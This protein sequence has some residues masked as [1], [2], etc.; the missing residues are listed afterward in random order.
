MNTFPLTVKNE[1]AILT[2][3]K[4]RE[5]TAVQYRKTE[6]KMKNSFNIMFISGKLGG[7]DGVS[8]EVDK[9]I[10]SFISQGHKIFTLAGKYICP[11]ENVKLE[12]QFHID[13][14]RFDHPEQLEIE[15]EV[16]PFIKNNH[17]VIDHKK[18]PKEIIEKIES[19]GKEIAE[20][21]LSYITENNIDLIIAENTNAMPMSMIGGMGVYILATKMKIATLFHHHDFWWERSRFSSNKIESLLNKIM[22]PNDNIVEHSV[23]TTYSAHI[24]RSL[25]RVQPIVIPNCENFTTPTVK[26]DYNSDFRKE[27]GFKEDD[28]L[29]IQPTRI[30]RRKK[31]EDSI[32]LLG[33]FQQKYPQYKGRIQYIISLYQG[34]EPDDNYIDQIHDLCK[35][36]EIPLHLISDRVSS[37]RGFNK[38][39]EKLY[40][41]RDVL[42]QCD[43]ATYLPVW[44]GFGNAL[45]EAIACRIP[46]VITTYLVY[47]TDI[48]ITG[49]NNIEIRD[50]YTDKGELI[51]DD[52]V[53]EEIFNILTNKKLREKMIKENFKIA[54]KE[55]GMKTLNDKLKHFLDGYEYEIKASRKRLE[56]IN[57]T[58]SV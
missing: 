4:Y 28:I 38:N 20:I 34:D 52:T 25:K 40:T 49:I 54:K 48:K 58:Y 29:I 13:D 18:Q 19:R 36:W 6:V 15:Q 39:G 17:P 47:K 41:N 23:L 3:I 8:L 42:V 44:E 53:Y 55:F 33:N 27:L 24:L 1:L 35:K 32:L 5:W 14:I 21:M 46:V 10:E 12:N 50:R 56:K 16:F 2:P 37:Q 45:L 57:I 9:W 7:T 26:D 43:L 51:I 11:I 31:I 22:P 30:V